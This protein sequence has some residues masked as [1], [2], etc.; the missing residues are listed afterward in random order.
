MKKRAL[1]YAR[2]SGDDRERDSLG[3]QLEL[4]R[5][6]AESRGYVVV[7]ELAE[8]EWGVSGADVE[9]AELNRAIELGA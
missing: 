1:L 8:D 6:Y 9:A 2:V 3:G 4:C 5:A 7:R